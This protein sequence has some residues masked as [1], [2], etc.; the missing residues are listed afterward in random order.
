MNKKDIDLY[1][2]AWG[3]FFST[4]E[5]ERFKEKMNINLSSEKLKDLR[6]AREELQK[7]NG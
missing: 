1:S 5:G 2:K 4:E 7:F 6:E 3:D